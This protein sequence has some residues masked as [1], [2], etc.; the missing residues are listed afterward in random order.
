VTQT[1][2]TTFYVDDGSGEAKV[3]IKE[4][5]HITKP[6]MKKDTVVTITGIVSRT[7][8]GYRILPRFQEDV[9]LGRVAGLKRFP[10]TGATLV[11]LEITTVW[12]ILKVY[13]EFRQPYRS[14]GRRKRHLAPA[15]Y[16]SSGPPE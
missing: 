5:T 7:N 1:S 3:Y 9:R 4:S 10:A 14:L 12:A 11:P 8:S 2:G 16:A 13:E 15:G 6:K